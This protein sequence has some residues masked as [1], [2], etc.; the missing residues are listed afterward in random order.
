M[1]LLHLAYQILTQLSVDDVKMAAQDYGLSY[2]YFKQKVKSIDTSEED[3][4][5]AVEC[6]VRVH[7]LKDQKVKEAHKIF[8]NQFKNNLKKEE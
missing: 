5:R 8:I 2:S 7:N 6:M 4:F 3:L 1:T